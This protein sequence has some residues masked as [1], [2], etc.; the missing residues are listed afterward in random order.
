VDVEVDV[1]VSVKD[2]LAVGVSVLEG[3]GDAVLE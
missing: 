3:V 1:T 2:A